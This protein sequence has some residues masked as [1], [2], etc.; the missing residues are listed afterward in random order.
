[1]Y[2]IDDTDDDTHCPSR[3]H[4]SIVIFNVNKIY[5]IKETLNTKKASWFDEWSYHMV[6]NRLSPVQ[7]FVDFLQYGFDLLYLPCKMEAI[8]WSIDF[9][10]G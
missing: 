9:Q 4:D 7:T 3:D 2:A 10:K 8:L 5:I 1:M 6:K